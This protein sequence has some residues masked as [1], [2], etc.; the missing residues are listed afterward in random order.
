MSG[1]LPLARHQRLF[2][3][4]SDLDP[5]TF[6]LVEAS[7]C[8]EVDPCVTRACASEAWDRLYESCDPF[9]RNLVYDR[10]SRVID[11]GDRVQEAWR[12]LLAHLHEYN[13]KRGQ[14]PAWLRS[15]VR[16]A[17]ADQYRSEHHF[18]QLDFVAELRLR[19]READPANEYDLSQAPQRIK[20]IIERLRPPTVSKTSYIV[21]YHRWVEGKSFHESA[22]E[23]GLTVKQVRDRHCRMMCKLRRMIGKRRI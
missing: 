3:T 8:K 19:S 13:P 15:V 9:I 22:D 20:S 16:H 11:G 2:P 14:F 7:V 23:L 5:E 17:L 1:R 12:A 4:I 21:V 18:H 6:Q 10:S